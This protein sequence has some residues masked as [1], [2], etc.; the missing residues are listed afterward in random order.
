MKISDL[1]YCKQ[2]LLDAID[3]FL[4]GNIDPSNIIQL[5]SESYLIHMMTVE[6]NEAE[7]EES[8]DLFPKFNILHRS[9]EFSQDEKKALTIIREASV[10]ELLK[11]IGIAYSENT[12]SVFSHL[13]ESGAD[14]VL[15]LMHLQYF[16]RTIRWPIKFVCTTSQLYLN[17]KEF[18]SCP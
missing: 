11:N 12:G 9:G 6:N 13:Q 17:Y 14:A 2:D 4:K 1:K 3:L 8:S 10:V 5:F 7:D 16:Y 15:S 18:G